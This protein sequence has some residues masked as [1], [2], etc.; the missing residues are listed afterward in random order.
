M[1]SLAAIQTDGTRCPLCSNP[2][3]CQ[4]CAVNPYKGPCWCAK[5]EIPDALLAQVPHDLRK[6][7]CICRD[8]VMKF[9]RSKNSKTAPLKISS[10]DFYFENGLM[11][12]TAACLLRR[13]YCCGS[14]CR[15]CPYGA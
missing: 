3:R 4:L 12:F 1:G 13:G 14:N 6:K 8:C 5:A 2:N 7:T 9:H 11:V 10:E 15:H